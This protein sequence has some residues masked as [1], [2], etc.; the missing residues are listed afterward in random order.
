MLAEVTPTL[1]CPVLMFTYYNP[2]MARGADIFCQQAKAAGVSGK[3]LAAPYL[4]FYTWFG[5]R[6]EVLHVC[7][8]AITTIIVYRTL[9]PSPSIFA[10]VNMHTHAFSPSPVIPFPICNFLQR[11]P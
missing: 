6:K 9:L 3:T 10:P 5:D 7:I 4:Q 1:R 8:Q 11:S 2:I